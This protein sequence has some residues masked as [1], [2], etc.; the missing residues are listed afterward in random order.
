MQSRFFE[1]HDTNKYLWFSNIFFILT[2]SKYL[3]V[4]IITDQIKKKR[5]EKK[6]VKDKRSRKNGQPDEYH[7]ITKNSKLTR[8]V[9][10]PR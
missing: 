2:R 10:I 7:S 9:L 6:L 8:N 3:F 4:V 5:K 1:I